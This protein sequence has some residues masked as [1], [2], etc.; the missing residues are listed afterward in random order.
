M[1]VPN[2]RPG[3][4]AAA[5]LAAMAILAAAAHGAEKG[6]PAYRQVKAELVRPRGGMPNVLA[7]LRAG[8]DVAIG[9]LGGS[10]TAQAGWR[11]MTLKWFQKAY[12]KAKVREIN[13]AIGGTPS[14]LGVFRLQQDVL[15]HKPDLVFVEFA[16]N[17]GGT[18]PQ[19]IWRAMEGI[20][21][22]IWRQDPTIDICYVYTIHTQAMHADYARGFC[23]RS[24]S[25]MELLADHYGIPSIDV[26][27]RIV[28]LHQA[29]K[30]V[31]KPATDPKTPKRLAGPV[32]KILFANDDCH[33]RPEGHKVYTDVIA[34]A[35]GAMASLGEPRP[36]TLKK[37]FIRDN[38]QDAK[39]VP[40]KAAMLT[41][42]WKKLPQSTGLGRRFARY[43]PELWQATRPGEKITFRFRGPRAG[44]YDIL[45]PDGGQAII[46]VDGVRRERPV[47]R[48]D[49]YCSYH[50][51]ATLPLARDLDPAKVH[52][53]EIEIHPEQPDRSPVTNR[54]KNK[55][56]FDPKKYDGTAL[57]VA[58][59][60]IIGQI[61]PE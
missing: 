55:K 24:T 50:R 33:P 25:A 43:M 39:I 22:Q 12:P 7:K 18:S 59:I 3:R 8:K 5:M 2:A 51:I 9:Y 56:N 6:A 26:G 11:V 40:L 21:R 60:L 30:L 35:V 48:F 49:H 13:A 47:K 20:V 28:Q 57:R 45:G 37:P 34:K 44:L 14:G 52:T 29:G 58:G 32:G 15:R 17:D 61:V 16:V 27:L 53:V 54:E 46:T 10:I 23:P 42:G 31:Y 36:H 38:W 41:A 19:D 4:C 1:T